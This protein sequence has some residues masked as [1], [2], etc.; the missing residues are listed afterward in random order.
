M[1]GL[2]AACTKSSAL[3]QRLHGLNPLAAGFSVATASLAW[4]AASLAT[5]G[6]AA[7]WS[8][9]LMLTGPAVMA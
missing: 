5:A 1:M 4:S 9:R 2:A 8:D 3:R 7:P 6:M